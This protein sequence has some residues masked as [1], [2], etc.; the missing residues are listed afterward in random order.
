MG[1]YLSQRQVVYQM[2]NE[3]LAE[4]Q[5]EE[6]SAGGSVGGGFVPGGSVAGGLVAGGSVG[7]MSLG[8]GFVGAMSVGGSVAGGSV[9]IM[10]VGCVVGR[11]SVGATVGGTGV[12]TMVG[13]ITVG[14]IRSCSCVGKSAVGM[15]FVGT[16]VGMGV[17]L[18]IAPVIGIKGATIPDCTLIA[19][20][21]RVRWSVSPHN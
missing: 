13:A 6:V 14:E 17:A 7:T 9:G 5:P 19:R 3:N 8:G 21:K 2:I 11:M 15:R 12:V 10:S 4:D 1:C 16:R 20:A 18:G